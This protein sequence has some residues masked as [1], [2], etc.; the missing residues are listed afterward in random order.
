MEMKQ[1]PLEWYYNLS[2]ED[3][4]LFDKVCENG[5]YFE[6]ML[7]KKGTHS[8][9][10]IK[11]KTLL[12]EGEWIDDEYGRPEELEYF[13]YS[14]FEFKVDHL[15]GCDA[16]F[17]PSEQLLCVDHE[18]LDD[19]PTILHEMIHLHEDWL[20]E[21]P[22]HYHDM[23][24]WSLYKNL[25]EHIPELDDLISNQAHILT[26]DSLYS[27][28]GLHDILFLLKSFDLDIQM[29]Y[30][31]GTVFAYGRSDLFSKYTYTK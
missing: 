17:R 10:L 20:N 15:E 6:D 3:R 14:F 18:S 21:L 28:G 4:K 11:C 31:L 22:L 27:S 7:F 9:D 16:Y 12:P 19:E 1:R 24:F 23:L 8:Y 25:K 29:N 30:P 5:C 13:D 26:E 2:D